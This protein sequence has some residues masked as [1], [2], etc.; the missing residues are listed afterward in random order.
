MLLQNW[1]DCRPPPSKA[2]RKPQVPAVAAA[3]MLSPRQPLRRNLSGPRRGLEGMTGVR[4]LDCLIS[5]FVFGFSC[6]LQLFPKTCYQS[7]GSC[8]FLYQAT[9]SK[10]RCNMGCE[11]LAEEKAPRGLRRPGIRIGGLQHPRRPPRRIVT[12]T[13]NL[14]SMTLLIISQLM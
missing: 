5:L 3:Q 11:S 13:P 8:Q 10:I 2:C 7:A 14:L 9:T 12:L 4:S 6:L 1:G